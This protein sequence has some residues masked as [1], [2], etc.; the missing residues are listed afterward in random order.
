MRASETF[1]RLLAGLAATRPRA[2]AL[3]EKRYGIWQPMTWA[4][5]AQRVHDFAYGLA[6]LG[7]QRGDVVAVLGDNRPESPKTRNR[8]TS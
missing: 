8:S 2:V 6:E 5:Y 4:Q 1:P 7:V 3:Q